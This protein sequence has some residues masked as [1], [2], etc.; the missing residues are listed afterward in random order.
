MSSVPKILVTRVVLVLGVAT[1][2]LSACGQKGPL[3]LPNDPDFNQRARLP[4]IVG[5]QFP[6]LPGTAKPATSATSAASAAAP[7]ASA[8]R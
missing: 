8:A 6:D 1:L 5:R 3:Y 2:L 4:D 7:A